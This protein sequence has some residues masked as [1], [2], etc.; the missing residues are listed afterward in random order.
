[1][2]L[3]LATTNAGKIREFTALLADV[4]GLELLTPA[5]VGGLVAVDEDGTTFAQNAEKKARIQADAF[6]VAVLAE[7]SGLEVDALGGRP[8][9]YSARYAGEGASDEKNLNKLLEELGDTPDEQRTAR[10]RAVMVLLDGKAP[11]LV[12]DG[13]CEGRIARAA[14]GSGG[15]GYDPIFLPRESHASGLRTMAEL[16]P[17]EKN[18]ISHRGQASRR[19]VEE[20]TKRLGGAR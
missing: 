18:R 5:D 8:G 4:S 7:D 2:R 1:M 14:C 6:G 15:F 19:L 17:D 9:V 10:Y 13:T 16:T 12:A 11:P 3:L 20:L